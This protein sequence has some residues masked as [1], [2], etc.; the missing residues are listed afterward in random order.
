MMATWSQ[1]TAEE[2][3]EKSK[4][5]FANGMRVMH[6]LGGGSVEVRGNR[7]IAQTKMTILQRGQFTAYNVTSLAS[8]DFTISSKN[9]RAVGA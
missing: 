3:I 4:K 7:A 6:L 5:S 9:E 8:G 1:G 2:F